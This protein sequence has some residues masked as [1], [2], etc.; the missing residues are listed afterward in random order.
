M[1]SIKKK[2]DKTGNDVQIGTVVEH[3]GQRNKFVELLMNPPIASTGFWY[4]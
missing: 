3:C 4:L 1:F 2:I